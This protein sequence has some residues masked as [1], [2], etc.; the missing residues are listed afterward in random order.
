MAEYQHK[1]R[2][3]LLR[4]VDLSR[5]VD[6]LDPATY[7]LAR[8]VRG[9]T[10]GTV[11]TR[12]GAAALAAALAGGAVH[13]LKRL[14][15]EIGPTLTTP[16]QAYARMAGA[17]TKLYSDNSAHTAFT[18]IASGLSGSP[19]S[20][21][22]IRPEQSPQ[23]WMYI[24]DTAK[25]LRA[26][27]SAAGDAVKSYQWGIAPPT[28]PFSI[29]LGSPLIKTIDD[30]EAGTFGGWA[31][32]GGA[33]TNP[34]RTAAVVI[35]NILYDTGTT[36]WA[37]VNPAAMG[38]I[39]EGEDLTTSAS[40]ETV[41]VDSIYK[42]ITTTTIGS[43]K[44]DSGTTGLCTIQLASPTAELVMNSMIRIAAAENVRVLSVTFG[45]DGIPSFRCS[46]TGTRAA[47]DAVAGLDSFRA[48]FA[49][50]HAAAETLSGKML[51]EVTAGAG[52]TTLTRTVALDLST[53]GSRPVLPSDLMVIGITT[54]NASLISE[55]QIQLDVDAT[56]NDFTKNYYLHAISPADLTPLVQQTLPQLTVQQRVIQRDQVRASDSLAGQLA[57]FSSQ[58]NTNQDVNVGEI[59]DTGILPDATPSVDQTATGATQWSV[60]K[61]PISD[62]IRVGS[63]TSRGL[64]NVAVIRISINCTAAVTVQVDDWYIIGGYGADSVLPNSTENAASPYFWTYRYRD[65]RTGDKSPWAPLNRSGFETSRNRIVLTP[66]V[67]SDAQVTKIDIARIGGTLNEFRIIGTMGNTGTFNDDFPD[68]VAAAGQAVSADD[69]LNL[70]QPF[71]VLDIPRTGTCDVKGTEVTWVSGDKFNVAAM[72]DSQILIN[73][74][75]YNLFTN[76]STDQQLSLLQNAGTQTGASF[77]IPDAF[78]QGQTLDAVFGPF[79]GADAPLTIFGVKRGT[80]YWTVGNDPSLGRTSYQVEVTGGS[81]VLMNGCLYDSRPYVLSNERMF[82]IVADGQGGYVTREVANSKGLWA[83]WGLCVGVDRIYAVCE[84]GIYESQGGAFV[85]ISQDLG[86]LLPHDGIAGV[87]VNGILPPDF[88]QTASHKLEYADNKVKWTFLDTGSVYRTWVFD[89]LK[90]GWESLD[91]YAF[92]G[93]VQYLEEAEGVHSELIGGKD[94]IIYQVGGTLDGST[95]IDGALKTGC[96]DCGET[97]SQKQFGDVQLDCNTGSVNLTVNVLTNNLVTTSATET[98]NNALRTYELLNINS[99]L[100]VTARNISL[101]LAWTGY[102]VLY[103]WNPSYIPRSDLATERTTDWFAPNGGQACWLQGVKI[104][105]D[106]FGVAKSFEV[107]GDNDTL[108]ATLSITHSGR[109]IEPFT[110][111][112]VFTHLVRLLP[113]G[114]TTDF[115][116]YSDPVWVSEMEPELALIWHTQPTTFDWPQFGHAYRAQIA[117]RSTADVT[118]IVTIDGVDYSYTIPNSGGE[119]EKTYVTLQAIKGKSFEFDFESSVGFRLYKRDCSVSVKAWSDIAAYQSATPFGTLSRLDG[120]NI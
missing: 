20:W 28:V 107:L 65:G 37:C 57:R 35:S 93:V 61:I 42:A 50:A 14:N 87:T 89:T 40:V 27:A 26:K 25:L 47:G 109:V 12:P 75:P 58:D 113:V 104:D 95:A 4:G 38:E 11:T 17:G 100:G 43:I 15:D 49:S 71:P 46:T 73:N 99:G 78:L 59:I 55:I 72:K 85:K 114:D 80:L 13:S 119:Y 44:Y 117:H 91:K 56:T 112:P 18:E 6:L 7:V 34:D 106:T 68:D 2:K 98:V 48:Y 102:V 39:R 41:K 31:T 84:D 29:A 53:F 19:L 97:R 90:R 1:S 70:A 88:A 82:E 115:L 33:L 108:I 23:P 118:M 96:E 30:M 54:D 16:T 5:P 64:K 62:L 69:I 94:G 22:P 24:H 86:P 116:M 63:D 8:N 105:I 83:P 51:R 66:T 77:F 74:V 110:W 9:Y 103:E 111:I 81:E 120:A 32:S 76:P 92:E 52:I 10:D 36:G 79:G 67:S 101:D 60:V 3:F 45:P 21:I